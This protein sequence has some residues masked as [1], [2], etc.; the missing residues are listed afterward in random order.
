MSL[1]LPKL[2]DGDGADHQLSFEFV[3]LDGLN[4]DILHNLDLKQA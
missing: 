2:D 3:R 1:R 4:E